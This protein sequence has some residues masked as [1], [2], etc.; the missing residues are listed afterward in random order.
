MKK[1][2]LIFSLFVGA[3][4]MAQNTNNYYDFTP[5]KLN[6]VDKTEFNDYRI[7]RDVIV[8][9]RALNIL[10]VED[11]SGGAVDLETS[12]G[13]WTTLET[14]G[15]FWKFDDA[16]NPHPFWSTLPV[17]LTG[18]YLQWDSYTPLEAG[19]A[20]FASTAVIGAIES[21]VINL[22]GQTNGAVVDFSVEALYC[23]NFSETPFNMYVSEDGGTTYGTAIPLDFGIDRNVATAAPLAY[24][25]DIS[26]YITNT[27]NNVKIKFEWKAQNADAN[28]Q[29]NTHYFWLIDDI[30]IFEIPVYEAINQKLWLA[31]IINAY[32][33]GDIPTTQAAGN[34]TMHSVVKNIGLTEPTNFGMT[35]TVF[36]LDTPLDTIWSGT[37]GVLSNPPF[38]TN[39]VDSLVFETGLDMTTLPVGSYGVSSILTHDNTD[40]IIDNDSLFRSFNITENT[41]SHIDYDQGFGRDNPGYEG[42]GETTTFYTTAATF[43]INNTIE[44]QG[45]DLFIDAGPDAS[46]TSSPSEIVVTVYET[47]TDFQ[48]PNF[49]AEYEFT[50]EASDI[51]TWR[52]FNFNRATGSD[53]DPLELT[54]NTL[55][56]V[57]ISVLDSDILWYGSNTIDSDF[58]SMYFSGS[59]WYNGGEEPGIR[60]NF[61]QT[62][63]IESENEINNISVSQNVPNPFNGNTVISY[64][65]NEASNV[66]LQVVDLTGKVVTTINEG[67][68]NAGEHNLTIDGSTLAEGTYF[69]TFTAGE[70]RVTKKMVVS[71]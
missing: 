55:Y 18:D 6:S 10:W 19:E 63:N 51:D 24:S 35:V 36:N 37:G 59:Q 52:T 54:A 15:A 30:R 31:D 33:Y 48:A 67:N 66:T 56:R 28:S 44:L 13:Q 20:T 41:L 14:D 23:C 26:S 7:S 2:Y 39:M 3:I 16:A 1:V 53:N 71:K 45:V 42:A 4:A 57:G 61:D 25:I 64:N 47:T 49:I 29:L 40:E 43:G 34:L 5:N 32:E 17:P 69:Y 65:L 8:D 11:F 9:D 27:P 70:Y 68:Q 62:L 50:L 22:S 12:N 46:L 58:S 38:V 21:P 60:L